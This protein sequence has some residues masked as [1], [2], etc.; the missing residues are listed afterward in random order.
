LEIFFSETA[1]FFMIFFSFVKDSTPSSSNNNNSPRNNNSPQRRRGKPLKRLNNNFKRNLKSQMSPQPPP[2]PILRPI[3]ENDFQNELDNFI[4]LRNSDS[5][6]STSSA[7][8]A[9]P[10]QELIWIRDDSDKKPAQST[11]SITKTSNNSSKSIPIDDE[12]EEGEIVETEVESIVDLLQQSVAAVE[13]SKIIVDLRSPRKSE[14]FFED[15]SA[16]GSGQVPKYKAFNESSKSPEVICLDSSQDVSAVDDSV[17]FVSEERATKVRKRLLIP[18]LAKPDCLKSPA[19]N[20]LLNL[21]PQ[22][23][24]KSQTLVEH[25]KKRKRERFRAYKEKKNNEFA[26]KAAAENGSVIEVDGKKDDEEDCSSEEHE[27]DSTASTSMPAPVETPAKAEKEKRI[28]LIDGPNVAMQY[29]DV[30]KGQRSDKDF[31]AEGKI[32]DIFGKI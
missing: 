26:A 28:V 25:G 7:V 17:I 30:Q 31:S 16:S 21:V 13:K 1:K 14:L 8:T 23:K 22:P 9:V 27:E 4:A 2:P 18:K 10:S 5:S 11:S 19:V 6:P 12:I 15:R 24:R 20:S 29:N 3:L 32:C